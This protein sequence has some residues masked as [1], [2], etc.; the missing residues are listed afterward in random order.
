MLAQHLGYMPTLGGNDF[1]LIS[2]YDNIIDRLIADI[3]TAEHHIHLLYYII[4]DDE[5]GRR[6]ADA[7]VRAV[8]RGVK[9]RVLVDSFGAL[10]FIKK[11]GD[12][13]TSQG[14]ELHYVLPIGFFRTRFTRIDLRNHRKIAVIDGR[15]AYTGS[16][17]IV[18]ADYGYDI[19]GLIY[20]ELMVRLTGP[21]V[22]QLQ[23]IFAGDWF[24]E[25]GETLKGVEIFPQ[26]EATGTVV[27]QS[28]PSGPA[29]KQPNFQ[30]MVVALIHHAKE[31]VVITT[32]YFIPDEPFL[33]AVETAV[34]NGVEVVL[35]VS[36]K[37][38][39]ALVGYAQ[40][41]YYQQLLEAG[42]RVFVFGRALLHAKHMSV[43]N[44]I[45]LIG[46]GNMDKRSFDLNFEIS[47]LFYNE[48]VT[49]ALRAE[50]AKYLEHAE[51]LNL[52]SWMERSNK[53]RFLQDISKLVSPLL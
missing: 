11:L 3:E 17:N 2:G 16:Q 37:V 6:L 22:L 18:N 46:S 42:I 43:D 28:L 49:Q 36:S 30:R 10:P 19:E 52:E 13:M 9:C 38:D 33:Q 50:E 4:A 32:P 8:E 44:N 23:A 25:S 5:T 40:S 39:Q 21:I 27:A 20:E 31:R 14:I 34:M 53:E 35:I 1:E 48:Q 29:Y 41:A 47:M 45:A 15:L 7:L 51:E 12:E 24:I 26:L